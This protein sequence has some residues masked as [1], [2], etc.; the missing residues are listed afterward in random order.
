MR[1][2]VFG[3]DAATLSL[4]HPWAARGDLPALGG[5]MRG[6]A[7]G[8]LASVPNMI[9]P[10]AWTSFAT[11]C[12]PG[13]HGIFYFT[14]RMPGSYGERF[15]KG[16]SRSAPPFWMLASKDGVRT[17]VVNVPMTFPADPLHGVMV[18][19]MDAPGP[20]A[21]GFTHPPELVSE[22]RARFGSLLEARSLS[23]A[24]GHLMLAGKADEAKDILTQRIHT[25]TELALR[26][27]E[28]N[29][30][31]LFVVVH[32]EVDGAQHY[33][34]RY[35]DPR[36]PG[37]S[38]HDRSRYGDVILRLYQAVDR[39]LETMTQSFRPDAI[40]IVSDHGAGPSPGPEDG[41]AWIRLVL[42]SAG[43]AALRSDPDP[44]RKTAR[45]AIGTLYRTLS[46]RLPQMIRRG[47]RRW[48]PG[49]RDVVRNAVRI[50][51]DWRHTRAF[52]MGAAG[53]VWL[54]V[55]GRDPEGIVEPDGEYEELRAEIRDTF[56]SL[57]EA[58]SGEP[59]VEAVEF[60]E[61]TYRGPFVHLAPDIFIRFRDVVIS[62]II[63]NG[64]V[65]RLSRRSAVT[66]KDVKSG[67]HRPDGMIAVAGSGIRSGIILKGAALI[68]VAPTL[69]Y[70]L[71]VPVPTGMDGRVLVDA[72][73]E[74]YLRAH[75]LRT[76]E[77]VSASAPTSADSYTPGEAEVVE[78]RLRDLG[79]V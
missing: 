56:L 2:L 18:S 3:I 9:T 31:D 73:T 63:H 66:P 79:Y 26:L 62:G 6:G 4:V 61:D 1:L 37:T 8:P 43:L 11:G 64:K 44:V 12:S 51:Y 5:L 75:P 49:A 27:M 35:L 30:T 15:I 68:D 71:G 39:S 20:D 72:F 33:F 58:Q 42:E 76:V 29:P 41:V 46:P 23:G 47:V 55:R 50:H 52:C 45:R 77:M 65:L 22:L 60:R 10:A 48:A 13:R 16:G 69:L 17:A 40:M 21:P 70:W 24:I 74:D 14:E 59:I 54:N 78:K 19:G 28:R 32:A 36:V 25:R 67:S 7:F 38:E 34:W 57:R 53:D